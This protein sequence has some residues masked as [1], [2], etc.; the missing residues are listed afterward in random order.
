MS[1]S[2]QAQAEAF[3]GLQPQA[4]ASAEAH[5]I[6]SP[7]QLTFS[8]GATASV[9]YS[10]RIVPTAPPPNGPVVIPIKIHVIGHVNGNG[11]VTVRV[12]NGFFFHMISIPNGTQDFDLIE[13]YYVSSDDPAPII[14]V[15]LYA[16][17]TAHEFRGPGW[18]HS[19]QALADPIFEMDQTEFD[20]MMGAESFTLANYFAFEYCPNL[21]DFIPECDSIDFNNDTSFFDP[22]D[23][24]A[25]LSVYGEGPC[26][27]E[28]AACND[29]DFNNDQS[30]FDPCDIDAFLTQFGEGPCTFCGV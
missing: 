3:G 1:Y 14:P 5:G 10:V 8:G 29:I 12:L 6:A 24:D 20:A 30:V 2:I 19:S 22:Q 28:E 7:T 27:P 15:E 26:I 18:P 21:I 16:N 11:T 4:I 17:A 25:F 9:S 13:T 23:I